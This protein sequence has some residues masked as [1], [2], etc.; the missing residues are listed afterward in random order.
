MLIHNNMSAKN[1]I[2]IYRCLFEDK[3]YNESTCII[4]ENSVVCDFV[5]EQLLHA[6]H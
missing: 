4:I 3:I 5:C 2:N 6:M 1:S